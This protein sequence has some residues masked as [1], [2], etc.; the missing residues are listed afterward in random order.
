MTEMD[1]TG[2]RATRR[3]GKGRDKIERQDGLERDRKGWRGTG[4]D[5]EG[6]D[7]VERD[8]TA[9]IE[10]GIESNGTKKN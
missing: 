4:Q 7:G 10:N 3:G 9:W 5:R 8:R 6:L 1:G 2:R